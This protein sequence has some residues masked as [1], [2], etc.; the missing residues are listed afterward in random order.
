MEYL[1]NQLFT[2]DTSPN[3]F[4]SPP[5]GAAYR[6]GN[7][8][9]TPPVKN[10]LSAKDVRYPA[11]VAPL[12]DG[13]LVTDYRPQCSKNVKP[14]YQYNTK[15]WM[16]HNAERIMDETRR[17]QMYVAGAG[18]PMANTVP[19]PAAVVKSSAFYSEVQ[20]TYAY[21]GIGLQ[22]ADSKAPDLF[23]TFYY[24]PSMLE[25]Q[26][27]RKNIQVTTMYEGGRN[28]LRGRY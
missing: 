13:R 14:G 1:N 23:G 7:T 28:S 5:L 20:P 19:P 6:A 11:Y 8:A 25:K 21:N 4:E 10:L 3:L 18:L 26:S 16:I 27:N 22:R 9:V 12:E 24:A 15:L 17:Q 2:N